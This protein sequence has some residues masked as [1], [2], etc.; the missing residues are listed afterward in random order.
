MILG[1]CFTKKNQHGMSLNDTYWK[2]DFLTIIKKLSE[3]SHFE[4]TIFEVDKY[5]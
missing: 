2:N 4:F 3:T 5:V 1:H